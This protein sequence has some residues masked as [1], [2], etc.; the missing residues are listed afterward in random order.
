MITK[1]NKQLSTYLIV[2]NNKLNACCVILNSSYNKQSTKIKAASSDFSNKGFPTNEGPV[3]V[4]V[5]SPLTD[6]L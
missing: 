1:Q 2:L 6:S 3:T 5:F 4:R